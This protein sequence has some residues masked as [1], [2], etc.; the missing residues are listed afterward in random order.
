MVAEAFIVLHILNNRSTAPI[1]MVLP[2]NLIN[3]MFVNTLSQIQ[4]LTR[5]IQ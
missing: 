1:K 5:Y 3:Y 4:V 2:G